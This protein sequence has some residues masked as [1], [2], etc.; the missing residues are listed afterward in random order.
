M[1]KKEPQAIDAIVSLSTIIN[2]GLKRNE[3][4]CILS[5]LENGV[6]P[7]ALATLILELRNSTVP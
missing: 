7:A 3:I 6:H 4:E 1:I 2:T 5:L